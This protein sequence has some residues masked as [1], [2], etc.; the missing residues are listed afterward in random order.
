M[1]GT[2]TPGPNPAALARVRYPGEMSRPGTRRPEHTRARPPDAHTATVALNHAPTTPVA[3]VPRS[4]RGRSVSRWSARSEARMYDLDGDLCAATGCQA[5]GGRPGQITR[6]RS[7]AAF[8]ARS[9]SRLSEFLASISAFRSGTHASEAGDF[10]P[11]SSFPGGDFPAGFTS[12]DVI[13][14]PRGRAQ[15]LANAVM[16]ICVAAFPCARFW[17]RNYLTFALSISAAPGNAAARLLYGLLC[18]G[19]RR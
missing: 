16:P 8:A 6:A 9:A 18:A 11:D 3:L 1:A 2:R 12:E 14:P 10:W 19:S 5:R 17:L 13:S 15:T 4:C 7:P